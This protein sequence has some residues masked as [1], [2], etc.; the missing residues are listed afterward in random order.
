MIFSEN[1]VFRGFILFIL[2]LGLY[3]LPGIIAFSNGKKNKV[4]ILVLNV[5]L[6]WTV[7]IWIVA[8]I[9]SLCND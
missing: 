6:G 5:L 9:W 2:F 8:L 7:V 4:A 1:D 3:P